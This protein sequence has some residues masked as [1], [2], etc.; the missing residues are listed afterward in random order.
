M[1][2]N[3]SNMLLKMKLMMNENKNII[4]LNMVL[5]LCVTILTVASI[6]SNKLSKNGCCK[7][8]CHQSK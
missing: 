8:Q 2:K 4:L 1:R 5:T 6:Y 7:C 3:K